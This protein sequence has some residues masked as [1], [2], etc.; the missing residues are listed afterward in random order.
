[1]KKSLCLLTALILLLS[2]AACGPEPAVPTAEP[3]SAPITTP[4]T[5]PTEP[6]EPETPWLLANR[7]APSYDDFFSQDR[8]Y[9]TCAYYEWLT[10]S[11]T[12]YSLRHDMS[13][14]YITKNYWDAEYR[15]PNTADLYDLPIIGADGKWGYLL[16]QNG[17]LRLDLLTG[18]TSL[19]VENGHILQ[20]ELRGYDVL[21]YAAE[22]NDGT[23]GIYRLYLPAMILDTVYDGITLD[24]QLGGFGFSIPGSTLGP[25]TW[26]SLNPE[27]VTRVTAELCDPDSPYKSD[28]AG[29]SIRTVH[30]WDDRGW[31]QEPGAYRNHALWLCY[32]LQQDTGIRTWYKCTYDSI[33]DTLSEDT[34]VIDNC[35]F[36]S[37]YAHDHFEPEITELPDPVPD[38]GEWVQIPDAALPASPTADELYAEGVYDHYHAGISQLAIHGNPLEPH[39]LHTRTEYT[40]TRLSDIPVTLAANSVY[41]IYCV[42]EDG[43][44]L[45]LS[46]DGAVLN[47]L[48]TAREEIRAI[49]QANGHL[50][51]LDGDTLIDLDIPAM[52]YRVL[53]EQTDIIEMQAWDEPGQ[54]YFCVA[55]GL[56]YQQYLYLTDTDEVERTHFL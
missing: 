2:L 32:W 37:G 52:Q 5:E 41:F 40:L 16:A 54:I 21:Y 3:T 8:S 19:I 42:T 43:R 33:A 45:Q 31:L 44:V 36:G 50:Y 12:V 29:N 48:Y 34:G 38:P 15:V 6:P 47:P 28:G 23:I 26:T 20:A 51:I 27:M 7:E 18:T 49:D 10:A 24:H 53:L 56:H 39:Y 35:W 30:L 17:I 14:L 9:G 25:I 4:T 22:T 11:G 13:G 1:M 55:R 46:R